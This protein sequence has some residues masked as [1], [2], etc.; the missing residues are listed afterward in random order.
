MEAKAAA[1]AELEAG[2]SVCGRSG[3][4]LCLL[5]VDSL[6]P[7]APASS[8]E[9]DPR[10]WDELLLRVPPGPWLVV[11]VLLLLLLMLRA[12]DGADCGN[13]AKA[14]AGT[15]AKADAGKDAKAEAGIEAKEEEAEA[16]AEA[17]AGANAADDD[18]ASL[19]W[20]KACSSPHSPARCWA[21]AWA[22]G[23]A[24]NVACRDQS[25]SEKAKAAAIEEEDDDDDDDGA[26]GAGAGAGAEGRDEG[27]KP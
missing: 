5:L 27:G 14:E 24:E 16:G 23:L 13:E 1:E 11:V 7:P 21:G 17:A 18:Q 22:G 6:P 10:G 25:C 3:L 26:A 2:R 9:R 8:D 20:L 19:S 12:V 15:A 4:R